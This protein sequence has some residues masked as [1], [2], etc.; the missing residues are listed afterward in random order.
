MKQ[1]IA[2]VRVHVQERSSTIEYFIIKKLQYNEAYACA[3]LT[4]EQMAQGNLL[5][6]PF[7]SASIRNTNYLDLNIYI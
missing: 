3:A 4:R 2:T 1:H 5:F 6:H 7:F